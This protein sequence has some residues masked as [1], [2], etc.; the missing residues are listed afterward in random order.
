MAILESDGWKYYAEFVKAYAFNAAGQSINDDPTLTTLQID[1]TPLRCNIPGLT[2]AAS[3]RIPLPANLEYQ[4]DAVTVLSSASTNTFLVSG[5]LW[6]VED[7]DKFDSGD[8]ELPVTLSKLVRVRT[9]FSLS[10]LRN[11]EFQILKKGYSGAASDVTVTRNY[12][13]GAALSFSNS[14]ANLDLR[15]RIKIWAK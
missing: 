2:V 9:Q 14:T 7:V 15:T 13:G 11:M 10:A 5:I 8:E 1:N 12:T 3:N 4:I 6:N